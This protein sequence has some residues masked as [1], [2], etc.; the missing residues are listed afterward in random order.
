[1]NKL[2]PNLKAEMARHGVTPKDIAK[3]LNRTVE[4]TRD[5]LNGRT[6]LTTLEAEIIRDEFFPDMSLDYL[7]KTK[8]KMGT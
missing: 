8:D 1:V 7:F 5:K 3:V 4:R 2:Y 6:K